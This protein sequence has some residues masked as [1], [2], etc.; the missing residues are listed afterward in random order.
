MLIG[1]LADSMSVIGDDV[2]LH[3]KL[4]SNSYVPRQRM[5]PLSFTGSPCRGSG[6]I[7]TVS[8]WKEVR[9]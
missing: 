8:V 5:I 6:A 1:G 9:R 2:A 4:K 3:I 7:F